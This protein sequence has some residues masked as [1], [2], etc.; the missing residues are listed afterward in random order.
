MVS[1]LAAVKWVLN[2]QGMV[3]QRHIVS[4][5]EI[6]FFPRW[7]QVRFTPSSDTVDLLHLVLS[8]CSSVF[9]HGWL[10]TLTMMRLRDGVCKILCQ[11]G[12]Y[13]MLHYQVHWLEEHVQPGV[14]VRS[15]DKGQL[16]SCS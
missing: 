11:S 15:K 3:A 6:N 2:W 14:I 16:Q 5:F 13:D 4:L 9:L 1:C 7:L 12:L 10:E 8:S